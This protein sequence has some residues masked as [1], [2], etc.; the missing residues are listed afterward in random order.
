MKTAMPSPSRDG[1]AVT[2]TLDIFERDRFRA[3]ILARASID[4]DQDE[5]FHAYRCA[6]ARNSE[7]DC[8]R[9]GRFVQLATFMDAEEDD[10]HSE[11]T[12]N[13]TEN[14]TFDILGRMERGE[15]TD[16]LA[17]DSAMLTFWTFGPELV[18][19]FSGTDGERV[20]TRANDPSFASGTTGLSTL[21]AFGAFDSIRV[22][23]TLAPR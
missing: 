4:E 17:G 9:P 11:C 21:N 1:N 3:G 7:I 2:I 8:A 20:V 22:C 23:E 10:V 18:C 16:V 5:G 12:T 15:T 13:C 19:E 6:V 14:T